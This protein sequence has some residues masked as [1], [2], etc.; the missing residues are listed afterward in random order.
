MW[1]SSNKKY[2]IRSMI[3]KLCITFTLLFGS[4]AMCQ[5]T[6]DILTISGRYGL[7]SAYDSIYN[8]KAKESGAMVGLVVPI[9]MSENSIWYNNVNYFY[10]HVGNNETMPLNIDNPINLHGIM[11]RT[12][13][14]QK[15][16]KNRGI[17]LFFSPRL[18]SNFRNI[19]IDHFQFGGLAMYEKRY[20]TKLK[21]G[22]GAMFNQEFFG[23][24]LV[25]LV[26]IDWKINNH[27]SIKGLLPIYVKIKYRVNDKLNVG[28][29]HFGLTTSYRLGNELYQGDY[30]E[31]KSIDETIFARYNI[32]GNIFL[33]GRIGRTFG[34][35]Y[36]QYDAHDKVNFSIPLVNFGDNRIQKNVSFEDGFIA[37]L[38]LIYSIPI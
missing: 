18:M 33:E 17:Q 13:L 26:N 24:Y 22:F 32:G 30:M 3:K 6:L 25:P 27:W 29:S 14:Y 2:Y 8:A 4:V 10:S 15:F 5:E 38:R 21:M 9:K 36:T 20:S 7:P 1:N 12:G 19:N 11:L 23:P 16:S 28:W 35:S 31:R 37:N 34:R